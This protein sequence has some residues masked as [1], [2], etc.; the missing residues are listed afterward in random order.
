MTFHHPRSLLL[1]SI[2]LLLVPSVASAQRPK[3]KLNQYKRMH[4]DALAK[5]VK[6]GAEQ[7]KEDLQGILKALPEDAESHYMLA[8]AHAKTGDHTAAVEAVRDAIQAGLPVSRFVTG[9]KTGLESLRDLDGFKEL[10]QSPDNLLAHG[11]MLGCVADTSV[12]VWVRTA[13]IRRVIVYA[14]EVDEVDQNTTVV[15][16]PATTSVASDHT[17]V[18]TL[19][20]LKPNTRYNYRVG[21]ANAD[22]TGEQIYDGGLFETIVAKGAPIQFRLAF[23]G[24]AGFR[25]PA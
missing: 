17:A 7:A 23:G 10:V 1:L 11:P 8:V 25:A 15:S 5:I 19:K 3:P 21:I 4:Q 13:G 9:T 12:R 20:G 16:A 24:G 22:G 14:T 2:V 6:G 18:M